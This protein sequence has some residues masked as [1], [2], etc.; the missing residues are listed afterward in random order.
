MVVADLLAQYY[1]WA[2]EDYRET[3]QVMY[4]IRKAM[5]WVGAAGYNTLPVEQFTPAKLLDI[6]AILKTSRDKNGEPRYCVKTVNSYV[7]ILKQ[8]FRW[9]LVREVLPLDNRVPKA[10]GQ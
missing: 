5:E 10:G 3:P 9:G 2:E 7:G 1:R 4:A 8:A 6:Q